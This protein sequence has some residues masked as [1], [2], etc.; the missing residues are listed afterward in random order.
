MDVQGANST[1]LVGDLS[2]Q[3]AT[4]RGGA[5][6]ALAAQATV[7]VGS[8]VIVGAD[9]ATSNARPALPPSLQQHMRA[10]TPAE[11]HAAEVYVLTHN[12]SEAY[13]QAYGRTDEKPCARH[14]EMAARIF[15]FPWVQERVR[16]LR[17]EAAAH[18]V[19]DVNEIVQ[20]DFAIIRAAAHAPRLSRHVYSCCRY[21]HGAAFEYQWTD[22]LEFA[23][24][25]IATEDENVQR[26][27]DAKRALPL[28]TDAGGY[29]FNPDN[30][31]NPMCP[32]CEGLG[33]GRTII[34]D[35]RELG[36][37]APLF[38]G[39]KQTANG[40]EV[41][42]HDVDKAKERVF[43]FLGVGGD[44]AASV[45]RGAAAGAAAGASAGVVAQAIA[46]AKAAESL[47]TDQVQQLYLRVMNG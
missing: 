8:A 19:V 36:P 4:G 41:L 13:R 29:G 20:A 23:A 24:K 27:I 2:H 16:A 10:C 22:Q 25:L 1:A 30:D 42:T 38:R 46:A 32:R 39:I 12:Q 15:A 6:G 33:H 43:K 5:G 37:A 35:T 17:A 34:G 47:T 18:F 9:V 14:W 3:L 21:C 28:P 45:A 11:A 44:D 40:I 7:P 26:R 31:P